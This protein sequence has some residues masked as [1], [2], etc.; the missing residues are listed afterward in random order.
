MDI[1]NDRDKMERL[2]G[3]LN[4]KLKIIAVSHFI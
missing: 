3:W 2:L 4:I 1:D